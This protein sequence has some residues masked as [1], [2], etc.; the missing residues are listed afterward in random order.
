MI[1][2]YLGQNELLIAVLFI[3]N[4][5]LTGRRTEKIVL[6][7]D[8]VEKTILEFL[9]QFYLVSLVPD[10]IWLANDF[11]ER[12]ILESLLSEQSHKKVKIRIPRTEKPLRLLGMAYENA[13]LIYLDIKNKIGISASEQLQEVLGLT[14]PPQTI[15]GIDVSNLQG[16]NPAIALVHFSDERP[17]KSRYRL[18]YP[19]TVEGQ[20]D[21]AM[22]Y[23][24]MNRR[25][26]KAD[27][28]P[29]DLILIDGGKGQ[30]AAAERALLE[31]KLDIPIL[32]LAKSRTKSAFTRKQVEKSEERIF[33]PK[34]KNPI[35]LKEGTPALRLLQQVR[36]EA[37]RFSVKSHRVRRR[38]EML[39]TSVLGDIP[40]IG[41]KTREKLLKELGSLENIREANLDQLLA[42]GLN[43]TQAHNVLE[44][45]QHEPEEE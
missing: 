19:K 8:S 7:L 11:D 10:E 20:N 29:P 15:E 34:R 43:H 6:T 24:V 22:I 27:P 38:K 45:L 35:I 30:L 26:S 14:E 18:Y 13:K 12:H 23:E 5:L 16:R 1:G 3:R 9:Q 41:E 4:G 31:L 25:F 39:E 33:V 37:H 36:D 28:P 40:G 21:F 42:L 44:N 17:L 2:V 32:A